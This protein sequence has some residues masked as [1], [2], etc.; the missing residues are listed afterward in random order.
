[1]RQPGSPSAKQQILRILAAHSDE[2]RE[3][4]VLRLALFGS[5]AKGTPGP[6]SDVDLLVQFASGCKTYDAFLGLA[7]FLEEILD[8]PVELITLEGLSPHLGPAILASA[9][10]A[11]AA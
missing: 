6:D 4:G 11:L 9:E 7:A 8:R 2:I 5:Y 1:M 10:D 3:R